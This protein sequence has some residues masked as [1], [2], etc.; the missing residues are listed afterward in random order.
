MN[1]QI[2]KH[3]ILFYYDADYIKDSWGYPVIFFSSHLSKNRMKLK[4]NRPKKDMYESA[5]EFVV[6][7]STCLRCCIMCFF[8]RIWWANWY[9]EAE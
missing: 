2:M 3:V 9:I 5:C 1:N 8:M 6:D 7:C 4:K